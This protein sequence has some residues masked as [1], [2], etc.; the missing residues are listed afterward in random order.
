MALYNPIPR[1]QTMQ[2]LNCVLDFKCHMTKWDGIK[3]LWSLTLSEVWI[4]MSGIHTIEP[5]SA[6][7]EIEQVLRI[8]D[9]EKSKRNF[10]SS[11]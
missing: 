8:L 7:E 9:Y 5:T 11:A 1:N 6:N 10:R 4:F 3:F 2:K